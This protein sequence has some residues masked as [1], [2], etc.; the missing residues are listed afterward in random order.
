MI[1]PL[2]VQAIVPTGVRVGKDLYPFHGGQE[3]SFE[4][5]LD[6][7]GNQAGVR[8]CKQPQQASQAHYAQGVVRHAQLGEL[9]ALVQRILNDQ[10]TTEV[11]AVHG[12]VQ[13]AKG[14]PVHELLQKV[15][16]R[17]DA[18][19]LLAARCAVGQAQVAHISVSCNE[20]PEK[21]Q[22][23]RREAV[24]AQVQHLE[25]AVLKHPREAGLD[26]HGTAGTAQPGVAEL[27]GLERRVALD[28]LTKK[29]Q[30]PQA[31]RNTAEVEEA[32]LRRSVFLKQPDQRSLRMSGSV[33]VFQAEPSERAEV[34]IRQQNILAEPGDGGIGQELT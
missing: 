18:V 17:G 31:H 14:G 20:L 13:A 1:R 29:P 30:I 12:D 33:R 8:S 11:Q 4:A 24:P 7:E 21:L 23:L 22:L 5:V 27:Q 25:A 3:L 28:S 15:H 26:V 32:Q 16:T 34:L 6:F 2:Q 19:V 10:R 9:P